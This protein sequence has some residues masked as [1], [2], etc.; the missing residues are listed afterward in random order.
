MPRSPITN[1][2]RWLLLPLALVPAGWPSEWSAAVA[3][4]EPQSP[5][6]EHP[7]AATKPFFGETVVRFASPERAR[8][9]LTRRDAFIMAMSPFDRQVRVGTAEPASTDQVLRYISRQALSWKA[10]ERARVGRLLKSLAGRMKRL[11]LNPPLPPVVDLVKTTGRDES[12]AAY[13]R[14]AAIILPQNVLQFSDKRLERLLAHELFHIISQHDPKLRRR[15]YA[16]VGFAPCG[17]IELPPELARRRLTNP[18]APRIDCCIEIEHEE[19]KITAAP[20]L[21]SRTETYDPQRAR[22]LFAYLQFRLLELQRQGNDRWVA[23]IRDGKPNLIDPRRS[24]SYMD[25]I[26]RNTRYIIH[27]DEILADNFVHLVFETEMLATPR[28]V[29]KMKAIMTAETP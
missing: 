23:A 7:P 15:L 26:G 14:R 22:S 8:E 16:I 25:K 1:C 4:A 6:R 9:I 3:A 27:P 24:K 20:V 5:E 29:Q 10:G 13:C 17:E 11:K 21:L 2:C 19:R 28:I 12:N 18:D